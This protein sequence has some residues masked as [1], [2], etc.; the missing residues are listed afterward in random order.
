MVV[1]Y[2]T[3]IPTYTNKV[4]INIRSDNWRNERS[5][6]PRNGF[7]NSD[8]GR[9]QENGFGRSSNGFGESSGDA[10]TMLVLTEYVGKIIGLFIPVYFSF[11]NLC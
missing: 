2:C 10:L 11:S 3:G 7:G 1:L 6:P 8:S 4:F 9:Q 5:P